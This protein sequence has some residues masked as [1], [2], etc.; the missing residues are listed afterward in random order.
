MIGTQRQKTNELFWIYM[1]HKQDSIG[2]ASLHDLETG[3][4]ETD[5]TA[6]A[7]PKK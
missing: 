1:K 6:N 5:Q 7:H 2:I 3:R 4:L